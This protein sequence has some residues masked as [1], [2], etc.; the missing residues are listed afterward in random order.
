MPLRIAV[1]LGRLAHIQFMSN[2]CS[3]GFRC[4][5]LVATRVPQVV[6]K[7]EVR[8]VQILS[9]RPFALLFSID[10][11]RRGSFTLRNLSP[12]ES[13]H[14]ALDAF[15]GAALLL[16]NRVQVNLARDF[17][18]RMTEQRLHRAKGRPYPVQHRGAA[19]AQQV[20][21]DI[22]PHLACRRL[23]I[24]LQEIAPV[25]KVTY[26]VG[27]KLPNGSAGTFDMTFDIFFDS[28]GSDVA[29]Y[30]TATSQCP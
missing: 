10:S 21:V 13:K 2:N 24:S 8:Y 5:L 27:P 6:E 7:V 18:S 12:V 16:R 25:A 9:P 1:R 26:F 23:D 3:I 29:W 17:G 14:Q 15:N 4:G 11:L 28:I 22:Q 20:P 30:V 19:V